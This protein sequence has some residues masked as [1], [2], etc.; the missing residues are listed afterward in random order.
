M[1]SRSLAVVSLGLCLIWLGAWRVAVGQDT[2]G[3]TFDWRSEWAVAEG[4]R[5]DRDTEGYHLPIAI[6]FVPE[7]GTGPKDPLYFVTEL[8]GKVKAVTND[9]SVYTFAEDFV[10]SRPLKELPEFA[11][12]TGLAG[13]CLAPAQGYVFVTFAYRA[14][15]PGS[16][17]G[18][19]GTPRMASGRATNIRREGGVLRNDIVRFETRPRTFSVQPSGRRAFTELFAGYEAAISHQIGSCQ[20]VG[21]V[22]Y[23]SVGDGWQTAES[24]RVDSLLGK[25]LRMTFDGKPAP[26]HPFP[27]DASA[28]AGLVWAYGLRNP[29]GLK[30]VGDRLFAADNGLKVDRFL[31]VRAGENY[32]WDGTDWSIG[33][34]AGLT[35]SPDIGPAQLEYYP[36]H[37]ALPESHDQSFFVAASSLDRPGVLRF[38]YRLQEGR[39]GSVPEY[40]VRYRGSGRQIVTG[41]A[42]GPDGLYFVP[43]LPDAQGRSAVLKAAYRPDQPHPFPL[44]HTTD[45]RALMEER[46]CLGC[47][48]MDGKGRTI[49]P[50]LDRRPL[51]ERLARRLHAQAYAESVSELDRLEG[52]PFRR[53]RAAR[54]EVLQASGRQK[55]RAWMTY[56]L[57]EPKFDNPESQMPNLGLSRAEAT[58]ITDYLLREAPSRERPRPPWLERG[59]KAV[60]R[61]LPTPLRPS[62]SSSVVLLAFGAGLIGGLLLSVVPRAA[63]RIGR[64]GRS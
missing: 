24:Q 56:H 26:G 25:V 51:Q 15:S 38:V 1:N 17:P 45:P 29:F 13:I 11:G 63:R 47:H 19:A 6:A 31:E 64:G 43:T 5:I 2:A 36:G 14:A 20:V 16:D 37:G 50:P 44:T 46:G 28:A 23:V 49:G 53:F 22:L 61:L 9:R 27:R 7:P 58:L 55:L 48:A 30:A 59:G 60:L 21:D 39:A 10:R 41:V 4:L 62:S 12:E 40:I 3:E 18:G 34:R 57:M 54:A 32:L 52:E 35:L 42:V 8:R 33:A